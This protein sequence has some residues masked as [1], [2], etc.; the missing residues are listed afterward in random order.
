M[1]TNLLDEY[2]FLLVNMSYIDFKQMKF[3]IFISQLYRLLSRDAI[4]VYQSGTIIWR[5]LTVETFCRIILS[6]V[7][8]DDEI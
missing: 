7:W 8:N 4:L 6:L 3:H 1:V 5:F 2:P